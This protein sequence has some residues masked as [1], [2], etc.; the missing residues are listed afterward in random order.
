[1][2]NPFKALGDL[3][4]VNIVHRKQ[5]ISMAGNAL[6]KQYGGTAM[7]WGW[8]VFHA[9]FYI[10]MYWF[11][12]VVGIRGSR[13][14][15]LDDGRKIPFIIWFLPGIIGWFLFRDVLSKGVS[16]IRKE[17]HL[18]NKIV[19]PI[20]TIPVFTVLSYTIT[21]VS[22]LGIVF[23]IYVFTGQPITI[24]F[25]Q[26]LYYIPLFF[27]FCCFV[28]TLISTIA[29]ISRDFEQLVKSVTIAFFWFTP[30]LWDLSKLDKRPFVQLIMKANPYYYFIQGYRETF[31]GQ[32]WFWEH[33]YHTLYFWGVLLVL[34][35]FTAVLQKKLQSEF[36]DVI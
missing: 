25:I 10:L 8:A 22:I 21:H 35:L 14:V 18:V 20:E 7:G 27:I 34:A 24:Y 9:A 29:V 6:K 26:L 11:G 19:F 23:L 16:C 36:A 5:T 17:S 31:M 15:T 30:V 32:A 4:R 33:K 1:M 28:C 12:I 3:I 2:I 13:F